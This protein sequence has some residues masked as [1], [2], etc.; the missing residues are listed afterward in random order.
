MSESPSRHARA[1]AI[2]PPPVRAIL[3]GDADLGEWSDFV[4]N[5][6]ERVWAERMACS[7]LDEIPA[8]EVLMCA[9]FLQPDAIPALEERCQREGLDAIRPLC[10]QFARDPWSLRHNQRISLR[11]ALQHGQERWHQRLAALLP[12]LELAPDF[13]A[14]LIQLERF[15]DLRGLIG[16]P[17]TAAE[18]PPPARA[19]VQDFVATWRGY[20]QRSETEQE[21]ERQS[22]LAAA[23][24][25]MPE[26]FA[27]S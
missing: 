27:K 17:E 5:T 15:A 26:L 9:R 24:K 21:L 7:T 20:L 19:A 18:L 13:P 4:L 22:L 8:H 6:V 12:E 25:L 11:D 2:L 16:G 14:W 1:L 3:R 23:G 10:E